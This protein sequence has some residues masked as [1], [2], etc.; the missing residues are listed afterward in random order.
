[1]ALVLDTQN[2]WPPRKGA[3]TMDTYG[4][5]CL[6]SLLPLKSEVSGRRN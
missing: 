1:M 6:S 4:M 2:V 5:V 3:N